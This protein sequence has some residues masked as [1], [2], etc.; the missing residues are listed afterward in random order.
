MLGLAVLCVVMLTASFAPHDLWFLAYLALV[1]WVIALHLWSN[2]RWGLVLGWGVGL[3]F[4]AVNLFWLWWITLVGYAAM[5]VYLSL[6]WLLGGLIVRGG[7]RRGL[8]IGGGSAQLRTTMNPI[9]SA[10][11]ESDI[12]TV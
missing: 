2:T 10:H 1:P 11:R 4:W 8:Q 7:L 12:S 9:G 3:V 5:V 6:Y